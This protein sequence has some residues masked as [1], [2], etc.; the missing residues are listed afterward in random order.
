MGGCLEAK[1]RETVGMRPG[2]DRNTR[3]QRGGH[4]FIERGTI[5]EMRTTRQRARGQHQH[6]WEEKQKKRKHDVLRKEVNLGLETLL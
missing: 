3:S 1:G 5:A 4:R 2:R 6:G